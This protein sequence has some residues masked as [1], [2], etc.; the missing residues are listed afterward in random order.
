MKSL[1]SEPRRRLPRVSILELLYWGGILAFI[2]TFLFR[3]STLY[4]TP[5]VN[6]TTSE[7]LAKLGP[8]LKNVGRDSRFESRSK[9][10]WSNLRTGETQSPEE[11]PSIKEKRWYYEVGFLNT[12]FLI[13]DFEDGRVC[14]IFMGGT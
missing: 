6:D 7:V 14:D 8:P 5:S 11:L 2:L 4:K 10:G 3:G 12:T 1:D 13:V 9:P